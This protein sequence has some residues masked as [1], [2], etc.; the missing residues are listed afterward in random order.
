MEDIFK[1]KTKKHSTR[2]KHSGISKSVFILFIFLSFITF[3]MLA[4]NRILYH[5][6][7]QTASDYVITKWNISKNS[8]SAYKWYVEETVNQDGRVVQLRFLENGNPCHFS[9][10]Y[11]S[12]IIKYEYPDSLHIIETEYECDGITPVN[13]LYCEVN[14]KT[15]YTLDSLHIINVEIEYFID[16]KGALKS[17]E[18]S[19]IDNADMKTEIDYFERHK[20]SLNIDKEFPVINYYSQSFA[21]YNGKYPINQKQEMYWIKNA[22]NEGGNNKIEMNEILK[23]IKRKN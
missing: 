12:N 16:K 10:C 20:K 3:P 1:N 11:L 5:A 17:G 18:Y 9:L 6:Y 2:V 19:S 8:L 4:Q 13:A 15:I 22:N 14:Y 7:E 21:K 23:S